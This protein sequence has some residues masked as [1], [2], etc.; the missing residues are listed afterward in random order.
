MIHNH[1]HQKAPLLLHACCQLHFPTDMITD[2]QK[3]EFYLLREASFWL[4]IMS[5]KNHGMTPLFNWLITLHMTK[6]SVK[7]KIPLQWLNLLTNSP[8]C[9]CFSPIKI[10]H[11]FYQCLSPLPTK[12]CKTIQQGFQRTC[13]ERHTDPTIQQL[14]LLGLQST[15]DNTTPPVPLDFPALG[16]VALSSWW[17]MQWSMQWN[18]CTSTPT[19]HPAVPNCRQLIGNP[20]CIFV[21]QL[22]SN[23]GW[24]K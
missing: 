5:R 7:H 6:P 8:Q 23:V 3:Q 9:S 16:R 11:H 15:L 13:A 21:G 12:W 22:V 24:A 4:H 1:A 17:S 10:M 18:I 20:D 19:R 14:L 2:W